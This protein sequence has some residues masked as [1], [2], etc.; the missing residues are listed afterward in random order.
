MR[1]TEKDF[2]QHFKDIMND[3]VYCKK[4]GRDLIEW[5]DKLDKE[6]KEL[7]EAI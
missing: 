5:D 3:N 1:M 7:Y 4:C 6:I 2:I